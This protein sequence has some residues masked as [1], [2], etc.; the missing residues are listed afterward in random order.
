MGREFRGSRYD[1][2]RPFVSI[3]ICLNRPVNSFRVAQL[4]E[5]AVYPEGVT[6]SQIENEEKMLGNGESLTRTYTVGLR[7]SGKEEDEYAEMYRFLDTLTSPRMNA[8]HKMKILWDD[9]GFERA[10]TDVMTGDVGADEKASIFPRFFLLISP[11]V[12]CTGHFS[13]V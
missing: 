9:F 6:K 7:G 4:T 10:V 2:A 5:S 13:P 3:W 1:S 12:V 11:A 8:E